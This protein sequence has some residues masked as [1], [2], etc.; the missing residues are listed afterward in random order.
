MP[1]LDNISDIIGA[2]VAPLLKYAVPRLGEIKDLNDPA[3]KGRVLVTIDSLGWDTNE[4]GAW[5]YPKDKKSV[6]TPKVG[7]FVIVEWMDG[8]PD[9]PMYS[10]VANNMKDM[11]PAAYDGSPDNQVLFEGRD[12]K[13][14][15]QYNESSD[16]MLIGK[17]D[18]RESARKEDATTSG[19]AEDSAFWA[20]FAAFFGIVTGLPIP[21]PGA[22][23]PS[24]LQ[25]AMAAAITGAGGT[26]SAMTGKIDAG[27]SQIKVGD[28]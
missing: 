25:A 23:S 8:M 1:G 6:V 3:K 11:L 17:T 27:S 12:G 13:V 21:E 20:F 24:A 14:K 2:I 28:K 19:S 18:F 15:V 7:D 22:G 9:I 16:E 4:K 10:G 26:P 5:C